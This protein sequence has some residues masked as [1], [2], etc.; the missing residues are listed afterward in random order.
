MQTASDTSP[1]PGWITPTKSLDSDQFRRELTFYFT[2]GSRDLRHAEV[3]GA[4][5][6]IVTGSVPE[7]TTNRIVLYI[8]MFFS[9]VVLC[10]NCLSTV[11]Q[12]TKSRR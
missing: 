5:D 1:D 4:Y 7:M 3:S 6:I 8:K 2:T 9:V 11:I 10:S 12:E